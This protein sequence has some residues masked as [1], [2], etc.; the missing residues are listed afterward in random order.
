M[1]RNKTAVMSATALLAALCYIGFQFFRIDIPIGVS[2]TAVHLGNTFC[3]LAALLIGGPAGGAA[4]AIGMGIADLTGGYA[5][6]APKTII[7]KWLIGMITGLFAHR[8]GKLEDHQSDRGYQLKWALIAS[9][10]AM[11]FNVIVDPIFSYFYKNYL[12]GIP[13]DAALIMTSWSAVSTLINAVTS[14][15]FA[16]LLYVY[17]APL[18]KNLRFLKK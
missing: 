18:I 3:I 17:V 12:L 14:V 5:T 9:S 7:M 8:F 6:S 1:K 11:L 13:S 10:A 2:K 4:G 16:S 15:I